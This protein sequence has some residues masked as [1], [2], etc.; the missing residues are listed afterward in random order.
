MTVKQESLER[1]FKKHSKHDNYLIATH[2]E[3]CR[4]QQNKKKGEL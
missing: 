1:L 3:R 4:G 2:P